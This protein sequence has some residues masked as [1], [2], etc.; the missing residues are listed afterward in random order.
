MKNNSYFGIVFGAIFGTIFYACEVTI[1]AR[2]IY[3]R[4]NGQGACSDTFPLFNVTQ[5]P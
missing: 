4:L 3:N 5:R 1:H 2:F